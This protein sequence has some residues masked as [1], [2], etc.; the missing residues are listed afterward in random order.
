MNKHVQE[1]ECF[2]EDRARNRRRSILSAALRL[3]GMV[4]LRD[5]KPRW[6]TLP[7]NAERHGKHI[8]VSVSEEHPVVTCFRVEFHVPLGAER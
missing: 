8:G 1:H 3:R 5:R 2:G 6:V 7:T 4:G